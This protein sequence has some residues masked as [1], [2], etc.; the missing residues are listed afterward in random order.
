MRIILL[1]VLR[2]SYPDP[3]ADGGR[4][5]IQRNAGGLAKTL[6]ASASALLAVVQDPPPGGLPLVLQ[7]LHVLTEATAPPQLLAVAC[8]QLYNSCRDARVLLPALRALDRATA[9]RMLPALLDLQPEQLRPALQRLVVPL[10]AAL[11]P[12]SQDQPAVPAVLSP[13]E[14]LSA[15]H[16]LEHSQDVVLLRKIMQAITVCISSPALFPPESLAA[17]INQLL[18]RV[19]LPQLFM[20]TV[21]QTASAAPRLRAFIISVLRQVGL[22]GVRSVTSIQVTSSPSMTAPFSRAALAPS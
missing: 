4:T 22:C 14:L 13:E 21:I 6:G 1:R 20:R 19:P 17:C 10:S 7:M 8:V 3:R 5:A 2:L 12:S 9:L 11:G 15:L 18:T 16:T